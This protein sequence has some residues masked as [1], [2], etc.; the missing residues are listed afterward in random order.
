[1]QACRACCEP[2]PISGGELFVL[3]SDQL[4]LA[5]DTHNNPPGAAHY[6]AGC[7]MDF[8]AIQALTADDMAQVDAKILAQL[9]SDVAS[10][11]N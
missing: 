5:T 3:G 10:L 9:N 8:K 6:F 11:I 4:S 1:M 2:L 7:T